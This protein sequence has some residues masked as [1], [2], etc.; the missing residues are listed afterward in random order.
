MATAFL[1]IKRAH[2]PLKGA[3]EACRAAAVEL[4]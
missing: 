2:E 1:L 4:G 3:M